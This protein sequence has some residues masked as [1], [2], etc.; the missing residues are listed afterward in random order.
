MLIQKGSIFRDIEEKRLAE[1]TSKGFEIAKKMEPEEKKKSLSQMNSEELDSHA[2]ELG[3]EFPEGSKVAE[4][5]EI[6][7]MFLESQKA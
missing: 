4:K 1:Y 2:T 7:K 3:V 5:K 6:I